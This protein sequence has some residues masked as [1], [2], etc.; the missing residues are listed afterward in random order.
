MATLNSDIP[1]DD[2]KPSMRR[3]ILNGLF[4]ENPTF[5][6]VLGLCPVL[7]TS[8]SVKNA[9]GMAIATTG[10]LVASNMLVS[11]LRKTIPDQIRLP[12]YIVIISTFVIIVE[13]LMKAYFP[14]LNKALGIFIP[15]IVVNCIILGRA[16]AFAGKNPVIQSMVD[17]LGM[18][19]GFL[20]SLT[21]VA[22]IRE[23][24]GHGTLLN[25]PLWRDIRP[26]MIFAFPPGAFITLGCL[27]G[28][29]NWWAQRR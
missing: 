25:I 10:V 28:I 29:K 9:A 21:I 8:T 19:L 4:K 1:Q 16:E 26:I 24:L 22:F 15:L 6:L 14:G 18:G 27:L 13:L 11:L 5:G 2:R 7:A 23:L 17:G 3:I 12:A 20:M